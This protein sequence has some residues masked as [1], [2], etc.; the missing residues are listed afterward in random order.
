MLNAS[1]AR[2][3]LVKAS[4]ENFGAF[5]CFDTKLKSVKV[6]YITKET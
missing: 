3:W 2:R 4:K 6:N 1:R 5:L